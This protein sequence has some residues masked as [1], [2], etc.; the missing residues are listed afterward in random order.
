MP[1]TAP[2]S[3]PF[4]GPPGPLATRIEPWLAPLS[5][6]PLTICQARTL[7]H[8]IAYLRA[9]SVELV[10][11]DLSIQ[12]QST[13]DPLHTLR[14]TS[15]TSV[16][17]ALAPQA[18]EV[19]ILDAFRRGAHEVPAAG[20]LNAPDASR[21]IARAGRHL[22]RSFPLVLYMSPRPTPPG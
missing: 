17:L 16:P 20:L 1:D 6:G 13:H 8:A 2:L 5:Q 19:L 12:D 15:P 3:I 9:R 22:P 4:L 7:P 14:A 18:D 10:L 21:M 11:L